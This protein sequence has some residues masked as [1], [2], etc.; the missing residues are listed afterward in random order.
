VFVQ[1]HKEIILLKP[2]EDGPPLA[3]PEVLL[4]EHTR[5]P[6]DRDDVP[7]Q[8]EITV[9]PVGEILH[10]TAN[11]WFM[12]LSYR[13]DLNFQPRVLL[14]STTV[15]ADFHPLDSGSNREQIV[16]VGGLIVKSAKFR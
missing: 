6:R 8:W 11:I 5:I 10:P 7:F 13:P 12:R 9:H 2:F 15:S 4:T 1:R 16:N 3:D 14:Q